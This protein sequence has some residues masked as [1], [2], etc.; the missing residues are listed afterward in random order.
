MHLTPTVAIGIGK[1]ASSHCRR[2]T[3]VLEAAENPSFPV[4]SVSTSGGWDTVRGL[5]KIPASGDQ[6]QGMQSLLC[7]LAQSYVDVFARDFPF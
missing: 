6:I 5:P 4:G 1:E 7:P 2:K 3:S